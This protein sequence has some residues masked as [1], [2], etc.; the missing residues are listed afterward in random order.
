MP[1]NTFN[2]AAGAMLN[3]R[4]LLFWSHDHCLH[5]ILHLLS[6]CHTHW[7]KWRQ[8][9]TEKQF[10]ISC[11]SA[12]LNLQNFNFMSK[13]YPQNVNL[14]LCTKFDQNRIIH[15]W[16]MKIMLFSK[17]RPSAILNFRKLQFWSRILYQ[18][19]IFHFH[20]KFRVN[21][22][23]WHRDIAKN[24]F[25]YGVCPPSWIC[26]ISIICQK[27]ILGMAICICVPNSIEIG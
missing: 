13:V 22:P 19:V 7:L 24:D 15:S 27:S 23:I 11:P 26:R 1:K 9:I 17:W 8:D 5:A 12:I 3:C 18:H 14:H 25:Q 2:V 16:D 21:R 10:S 20:S 6:N 4:K